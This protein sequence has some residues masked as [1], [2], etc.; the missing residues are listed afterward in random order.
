L[1]DGGFFTVCIPPEVL[2]TFQKECLF[3]GFTTKEMNMIKSVPE[4][5][6]KRYVIT[7][8]KGK[9]EATIINTYC[10]RDADRSVSQ[11]YKD[12]MQDFLL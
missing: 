12:L 6:P 4:K 10:M 3:A 1:A 11:W 8:K 2:E 7:F 9:P 5:G